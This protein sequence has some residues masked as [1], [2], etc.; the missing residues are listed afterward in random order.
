IPLGGTT[1]PPPA[2]T[3]LTATAGNAQVSLSWTAS[4]GATSYNVLRS[5]T[6]GTGYV[7]VATGLTT[8]TFVNTG[9]TT[10]TTSF[11]VVTATNSAGTSGNSNQ[12]S[13]RPTLP[14]PT[15][16]TGLTA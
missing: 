13:A 15:P 5:T 6:G 1:T 9:L 16:P 4:T 3:G 11:F 2:P 7:S 10:A 8:T 14:I 12:A